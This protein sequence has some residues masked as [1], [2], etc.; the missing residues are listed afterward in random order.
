MSPAP[1][2]FSRRGSDRIL[3]IH[4]ECHAPLR[5]ASA[6]THSAERI[7]KITLSARHGQSAA[8][9]EHARASDESIRYR[10]SDTRLA[11]PN[12]TYRGEAAI[13]SVTQHFGR[14]TRHISQWLGLNIRH[15]KAGA[16]NMAVC[17]DQ[18]GHQSLPS[19]V[20]DFPL[21]RSAR[22]SFHGNDPIALDDDNRIVQVFS[23]HA[24]EDSS[25]HECCPIHAPPTCSTALTEDLM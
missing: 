25:V 9:K 1:Q 23:V 8:R 2:F 19:D 14:I 10:P 12:V 24:V 7:S 22:R 18:S 6:G 20:D 3:A 5:R 13:E 15:L 11:A 4:H 16:Q 17:V 21:H